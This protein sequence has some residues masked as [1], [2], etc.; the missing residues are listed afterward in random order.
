VRALLQ[1]VSRAAVRV[2]A[3]TVAS[4]G[5]GLVVLLGVGHADD[6]SIAESLARRVAELRIFEASGHMTFVEEPDVYIATVRSFLTRT[7]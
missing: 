4:I 7:A 1:R 6:E 3:E 5:P 2:D